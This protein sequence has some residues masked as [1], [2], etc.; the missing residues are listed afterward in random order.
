MRKTVEGWISS[1]LERI[2]RVGIFELGSASRAIAASC[3]LALR[4]V[5]VGL[6]GIECKIPKPI[7]FAIKIKFFIL[8]LVLY[9]KPMGNTLLVLAAGM[10]SRYGGLKQIDPVGPSG[11]VVLDYS[12]HDALRCGFDRVVFVIRREFEREF[13]EAVL[14]RYEGRVDVALVFQDM[15]DLPSGFAL[16][17]GRTKPWGTGHAILSA[18]D[19]VD[20]P[21]LVVNADD[22]YGAEAFTAMKGFLDQAGGEGLQMAL[23]A[24]R[25][26]NT[27][28]EN[29]SVARGICRVKEDGHLASVEEHT[30]ILCEPSGVIFGINST[31]EKT[32]L[33]ADDFVSMNFWGFS[34]DVFSHL[35]R[36][37]G[38]F[39]EGGGLEDP[40][41]EFYIPSAV[42][43]LIA[44]GVAKVRV[45][46][47]ASRW[48]GVTYREDRATVAEAVGR[49]V[50]SGS[51]PSPLWKK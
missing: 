46:D 18:R 43:K 3:S 39:L 28:S 12:V 24:Y 29:G 25:L 49:M 50:E 20:G 33:A 31:G 35:R 27:L 21:F 16:P 1:F 8:A 15:D 34:S 4:A 19:A 11:E 23:V 41:A 42:S 44:S 6:R 30:G 26:A 9:E 48:Y 45:L 5:N 51:Y 17:N 32:N 2:E 7:L 10:G 38:E 36:L 47:S 40:K 37:F 14:S 13:R 22:F